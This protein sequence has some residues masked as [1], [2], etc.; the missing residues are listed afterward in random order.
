MNLRIEEKKM[1][2]KND[3]QL[4]AALKVLFNKSE[5]T[6]CPHFLFSESKFSIF[7]LKFLLFHKKHS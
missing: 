6:G 3:L 5:G 2:E 1:D 4:Q 7:Y